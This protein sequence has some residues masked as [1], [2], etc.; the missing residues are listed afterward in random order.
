MKEW[1]GMF[2]LGMLLG[3]MIIILAYELP[4][5]PEQTSDKII[6][7]YIGPDW[8]AVDLYAEDRWTQ[9][10]F[11]WVCSISVEDIDFYNPEDTLTMYG[12]ISRPCTVTVV[13]TVCADEI[14]LWQ[15]LQIIEN[16]PKIQTA[17]SEFLNVLFIADFLPA[18]DK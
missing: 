8:E 4:S 17:V 7:I 9:H 6:G 10:E 5:Q 15:I 14:E 18:E 3:A 12:A 11:Y 1:I 13:D 16:D 2:L